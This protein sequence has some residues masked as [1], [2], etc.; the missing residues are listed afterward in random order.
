MKT[1]N[2]SATFLWLLCITGSLFFSCT[3]DFLERPPLGSLDEENYIGTEE[4][5]FKLLVNCYLPLAANWE[6]Q[7]MRFDIGDQLTDDA[8]KGGSDAGD[9]STITELTRGNPLATN[10]LLTD[11]WNHRY[12]TAISACNV[13]LNLITPETELIESGGALVSEAKKRRWIAEAHFLRAF[14]YYDLATV[15]INIPLIQEP[16]NA[17]DKNDIVK[18]DKEA[19]KAFILA[20]LEKALNESNIPGAG[21]LSSSELGRVTKE[22]IR[23][24]RARV[25]LFYGDYASA[26]PDLKAVID[27]GQ[28]DLVDDYEDLFNSAEKGYKSKEAVFITLRDY[29]ASY[30]EG[31]VCPIMNVGRGAVGGW[32]GDCPTHD[33]VSEYETGDP[34]LVH[35]VMSTGDIFVKPDGSEELHDY[36]RYDNF[37]QQHSRKQYPDWSRRPTGNLQQ[38]DWT[39]YHIRYADVLLMYAECLLETGGDKQ[40]VADILNKIRYRAF[41]TTSPVDTYAKHRKF[42]I[43]EAERITEAIFHEKYKVR[44][45]DNLTAALRHERRIELAGEGLRFYDLIRWGTFTATMQSFGQTAEGIYSGAGTMV[46]GK[47]WPYPIPQSEIDYVGGALTQND[48][49]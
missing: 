18:S 4:A 2:Q 21:D 5:G 37:T 13:F 49:Y 24:F 16:M 31:C 27:S 45:T 17:I 32:G 22:A 26:L 28:F 19:V 14:Y 35:T 41:V 10:T 47:T 7:N 36:S 39:Y 38:T 8:A 23:A 12:K 20:D 11:L 30:T 42:N 15:F 25:Y 46:S 40:E 6:Y 48:N 3:A 34:R 1:L 43:P 44:V 29:I 9:R 33:L